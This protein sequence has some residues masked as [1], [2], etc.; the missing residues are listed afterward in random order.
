MS[1]KFAIRPAPRKR[2]WI[3]KASP[4]PLAI[5]SAP[6]SLYATIYLATDAPPPPAVLFDQTLV[7]TPHPPSNTYRA[8]WI[9]GPDS[10]GCFFY[11]PSLP[12]HP[13]VRL[14]WNIGGLTDQGDTPPAQ[15]KPWPNLSYAA[16]DF[17]NPL[18]PYR[19]RVRIT[20]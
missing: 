2:P 5:P 18:P 8:V 3:C 1:S 16:F 19:T 15:V 9:S 17:A 14:T 13:Y 10:V 20:A 4:A 11:W 6:P 12:V 7:L